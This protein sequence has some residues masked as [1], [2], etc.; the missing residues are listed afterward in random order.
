MIINN[1]ET[2]LFQNETD[3]NLLV[4]YYFALKQKL[5]RKFK[6]LPDE[7]VSHFE[8]Y[9]IKLTEKEAEELQSF[10]EDGGYNDEIIEK[11][12]EKNEGEDWLIEF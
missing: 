6:P 2:T 10:A 4:F 5:R 12:R 1:R 3:T 7:I 11:L 9:K 8:T